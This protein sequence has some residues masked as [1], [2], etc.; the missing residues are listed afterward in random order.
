MSMNDAAK[1]AL[2]PRWLALWPLLLLLA[3]VAFAGFWLRSAWPALL[4]QGI[5]W[6][7]V[8]HDRMIA[9][10][11]Q[12]HD[13]PHQAGAVLMLFSLLYG[14]FHAAGPGHGKVVIV[15]YLTTHPA[16]LK[17][18][19]QLTLLASLLQ[20]AVAVV[21]VT[22]MLGVLHLSSRQLHL[23]SFWLERMSYLLVAGLGA[24]LSLRAGRAAWQSVRAL[25]Q[26]IRRLVP[27]GHVHSA[28]CGC[29]HRHMPSDDELKG[30]AGWRTRA[31]LVLSM[32]LRPCSGA[33]MMLLFSKVIGV[34]VWGV[35]SAF[36]MAIGT[37][38]TLSLL[39][40]FV[41]SFRA[42]ALRSQRGRPAPAWW[43]IARPTLALAG[44]LLLIAASILL[45]F[46]AQPALSGG[47]RPLFR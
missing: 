16:R 7:K 13:A 25:R 12:V 41:H 44:G 36:V 9:L 21:L 1:A 42:L 33:L 11:Q 43:R 35:L 6:Q 24:Y 26:P 29:G 45:W 5:Q 30:A 23:S 20:G 27:V 10:L 8:F 47:L 34:Y 4:F 3:G 19:L 37:S 2:R 18:S 14:I 22:L 15:T 38:L 17:S 28:D 32:G 31:A 46:T 39:A 40:L